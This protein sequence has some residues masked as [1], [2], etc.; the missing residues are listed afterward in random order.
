MVNSIAVQ[1]EPYFFF[2]EISY[3]IFFLVYQH[4]THGKE[5]HLKSSSELG[6]QVQFMIILS[7]NLTLIQLIPGKI[8][9][10]FLPFLTSLGLLTIP[11]FW[12]PL[13]F[14]L[15]TP[16]MEPVVLNTFYTLFKNMFDFI[17]ILLKYEPTYSKDLSK[18]NI[19]LK[20]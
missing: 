1:L 3:L 19:Q 18:S 16:Y 17:G 8:V 20:K 6:Q 5:F 7:I 12:L 2:I 14:C 10:S 9:S 4:L 13:Y 11:P 15:L